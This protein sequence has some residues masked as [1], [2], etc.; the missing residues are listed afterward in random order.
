MFPASENQRRISRCSTFYFIRAKGQF[1]FRLL[2]KRMHSV[3]ITMS[4]REFPSGITWSTIMGVENNSVS[5]ISRLAS[6][7]AI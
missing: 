4:S 7:K 2:L 1:S 3:I 5:A 6:D